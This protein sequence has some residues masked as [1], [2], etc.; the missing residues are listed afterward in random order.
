MVELT[1]KLLDVMGHIQFNFGS[2]ELIEIFGKENYS[3]MGLKWVQSKYNLLNFW[4]LLDSENKEL[5]FQYLKKQV[6]FLE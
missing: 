6:F 2:E 5:F 4:G 1:K 3:H